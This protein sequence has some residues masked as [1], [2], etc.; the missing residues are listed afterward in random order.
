MEIYGAE[1]RLLRMVKTS[2]VTASKARLPVY[3][4]TKVRVVA[5][6]KLDAVPITVTVYVPAGVPP[7]V[8]FPP[9]ALPLPPPQ[10]YSVAP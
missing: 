2:D 7:P 1:G 4:T 10:A 5:F 6:D 3:C 8:A 9:P